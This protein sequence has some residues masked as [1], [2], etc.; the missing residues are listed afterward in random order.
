ML[1]SVIARQTSTTSFHPDNVIPTGDWIWVFGSNEGGRHGK[2]AAKIA[3][4]NFRAEYGVGRGPTG[5]AYAIPTKDKHLNVLPLDKI[6]ADIALFLEY[7][8]ANPKLNFFVTAVGCGL[9]GYSHDAIGPRFADAPN[10]CSLPDVWK[11]YVVARHAKPL[12]PDTEK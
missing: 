8:R 5:H 2:G 12:P 3:R 4:I 9:A 10:N 6:E 7:A 1:D 11:Q